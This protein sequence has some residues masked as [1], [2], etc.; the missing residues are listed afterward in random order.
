ML[1]DPPVG[2]ASLA[3][4]ELGV[5]ERAALSALRQRR[6]GVCA[7][8]HAVFADCFDRCKAC[9]KTFGA[10]TGTRAVGACTIRSA[11]WPSAPR[12]AQAPRRSE[13]LPSA[14][15]LRRARRIRW[16]TSPEGQ[17]G[18]VCATASKRR[19]RLA[20]IVR[21]GRDLRSRRAGA[22]AERKLDSQRRAGAGGKLSQVR[23]Q[24]AHRARLS[25]EQVPILV[26]RRSRRRPT[27]SH[28]GLRP[29]DSCRTQRAS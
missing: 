15:G 22:T 3:A 18:G 19:H 16:P 2:A 24:A 29:P 25:R 23:P 9:G 28:K 26:C 4:I 11:G 7:A 27:L 14:A 21:G 10:L 8:R 17:P 1:S 13:R 20:G 12:L 6:G 5:D